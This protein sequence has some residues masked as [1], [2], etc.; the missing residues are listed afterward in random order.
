MKF[1]PLQQRSLFLLWES[2]PCRCI[3]IILCYISKVTFQKWHFKSDISEVTFQNRHFKSDILR[4]HL[5][6]LL[7]CSDKQLAEEF[8]FVAIADIFWLKKKLNIR[9]FFREEA[10][11]LWVLRGLILLFISGYISFTPFNLALMKSPVYI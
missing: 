2:L 1:F 10:L 4:F 6:K 7:S 8:L 3:K 5:T 9:T 11:F